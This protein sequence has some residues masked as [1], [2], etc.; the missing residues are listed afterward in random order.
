M[1]DIRFRG[2]RIDNGE[3]VSG[4]YGW[5]M[6]KHY[7]SVVNVEHPTQTD[8]GGYYFEKS[9]DVL[10][11]TI[12]QYTGHSIKGM[13][14]FED[15]IVRL[16]ENGE[17][18]DPEDKITFYVVTWIKEWCMFSLLRIEDEYFEYKHGDIDNLDTSM[19]WTFPLDVEDIGPSQHYLVG[20]IHS[21]PELLPPQ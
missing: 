1:R 12:G 11:E 4:F 20:D 2:K 10:E 14:L 9:Y 7:I 16:E 3:W 5:S 21:N 17:G 13:D 8:P 19:F 18:V 6:G 15:D